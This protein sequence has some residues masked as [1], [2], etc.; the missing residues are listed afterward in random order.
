MKKINLFHK[1]NKPTLSTIH[2]NTMKLRNNLPTFL[3]V[4]EMS[5]IFLVKK[6]DNF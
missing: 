4:K 5:K 3:G 6:V 1:I 2:K